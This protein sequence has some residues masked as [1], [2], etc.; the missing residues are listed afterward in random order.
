MLQDSI[1]IEKR[2]KRFIKTV[3]ESEVV[4]TLKD[5]KGFATSNSM[6]HENDEEEPIGI[7]CFWAEKAL[8]KSC[9]KDHWSKYKVVEITLT[10]FIEAWCIGMENDGLMIGTEF[11]RNM[12]GFEAKPLE[13]INDLAT[14]L[15]SNGKDLNFK[16]FSGIKE[17]ENRM[18]AITKN[19]N[20]MAK[21][22]TTS[23]W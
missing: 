6:N 1:I 15:E 19:K 23:F 10:E 21:N 13:L 5:T 22:N 9:I 8:A 11:D 16:K 14:E 4:Y 3:C 12:F 20:A 2:H 17:I 7:I 18:K